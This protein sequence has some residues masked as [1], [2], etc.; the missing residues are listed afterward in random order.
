ALEKARVS[1][2]MQDDLEERRRAERVRREAEERYRAFVANSSEGIYRLEFEP[3][4]DTS[5]SVEE[6]IRA[7][8]ASG[9]L[10]ECNDAFARMYGYEHGADMIGFEVDRLLPAADPDCLE[11]VRRVIDAHYSV[12]DAESVEMNRQGERV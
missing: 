1:R 7:A 3:P 6:Q 8:Y 5:L 10:E 9:R 4:V 2:R 12:V 11:H